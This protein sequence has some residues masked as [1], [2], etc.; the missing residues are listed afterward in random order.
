MLTFTPVGFTRTCAGAIAGD[1]ASSTAATSQR[2]AKQSQLSERIETYSA[3]ERPVHSGDAIA[4][5]SFQYR[6]I[7]GRLSLIPEKDPSR[8]P[9]RATSEQPEVLRQLGRHLRIVAF[10]G[11]RIVAQ[12][13]GRHCAREGEVLGCAEVDIRADTARIVLL[14]ELLVVRVFESERGAK[15]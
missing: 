1:A 11:A 15:V 10:R 9:L 12:P 14:A 6:D 13:C 3:V 2:N 8:R 4:A 5:D 7:V